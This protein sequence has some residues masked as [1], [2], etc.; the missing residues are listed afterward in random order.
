MTVTCWDQSGGL[1]DDGNVSQASTLT[2]IKQ[3]RYEK[4]DG[5]L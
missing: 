3:E 2:V 5:N 1:T 4:E